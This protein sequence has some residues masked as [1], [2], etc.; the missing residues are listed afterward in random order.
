MDTT[1]QDIQAALQSSTNPG[2]YDV[3]L[4]HLQGDY[5]SGTLTV[6]APNAFVAKWVANRLS[7]VILNAAAMVLGQ[8]PRLAVEHGQAAAPGQTPPKPVPAQ[9]LPCIPRPTSSDTQPQEQLCSRISPPHQAQ[10]GLPLESP[11]PLHPTGNGQQWRFSFSDFVVGPCNELAYAAAKNICSQT[12]PA[13]HLFISS[14]PGLGKTHLLQAAGAELCRTANGRAPRVAYLTGEEFARQMVFALR[15]GNLERFKS[16]YRDSVDLL[17]LEDVHFFQGKEKMQ[18]ELLATLKALRSNG[19]KVVFSSSFLPREIKEL[20]SQLASR[21]CSGFLAVIDNPDFET[22]RRILDHKARLFQVTL[23]DEVSQLLAERVVNDIRQL[24]SCLQ[25]LVLKARLLNRS[26]TMDLAWQVLENYTVQELRCS[27][28]RIVEFICSS[29]ELT[30][31]QLRSK[32]RQRQIVLARNMAFFLT[33]QYTD[34]S[35]QDI[36][37]RFNRKHSTVLK[38]IANVEREMSLETPLG[39]QLARTIEMLQRF[40]GEQSRA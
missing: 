8:R 39:R 2:L 24:E 32:S 23:P 40:S 1:W 19:A 16:K 28:E 29:F 4:K 25:N 33:R 34:L 22:R 38:G 5:D 27:V 17:L 31:Q 7:D 21:F 11:V 14:R 26:I 6:R 18:D 37:D 3:W 36:G 9:N 13:D 35:L 10:V 30:T 12:L 15:S 20:D